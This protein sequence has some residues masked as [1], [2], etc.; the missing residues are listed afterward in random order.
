ML[1]NNKGYVTEYWMFNNIVDCGE[2]SKE[3]EL[4]SNI[5][6]SEL[7]QQML[8]EYEE[9]LNNSFS[10]SRLSRD[11]ENKQ[12]NLVASNN[13]RSNYVLNDYDCY[14]EDRKNREQKTN[15]KHNNITKSYKFRKNK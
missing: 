7:E 12:N 15:K 11:E 3:Q 14:P 9:K 8:I 5:A 13:S 4:D 6:I 1:I 10:A 2:I